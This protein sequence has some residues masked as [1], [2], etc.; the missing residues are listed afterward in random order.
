MSQ[1]DS[2][3]ERSNPWGNAS[4]A[5]ITRYVEWV[6]TDAAG[7]QHNSSIMRWVESAEA[8]LF[9]QLALPEYFPCAPRVQ[10]T[11]NFRSKLWFSQQIS[12]TIWVESMGEKSMTFGFEITAA[13][14]ETKPGG[15]AANGS[16]TTAHVAQGALRASPWP[17]NFRSIVRSAQE[18]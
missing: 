15:L 7:H 6:D 5:T 8:E 14:L 9:R 1:A 13:P 4:H 16:F 12:A 18:C 10:Q 11:I 17:E 2:Q 3:A